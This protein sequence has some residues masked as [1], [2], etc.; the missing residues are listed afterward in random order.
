VLGPIEVLMLKVKQQAGRYALGILA[1]VIA[2]LLRGLLDPLLGRENPYHTVWLAVVFSTWY[3]GVG[4]AIVTTILS[5]AGVWFF[6]LPPIDSFRGLTYSQFFGM[7]GFL[8]LSG[9][10]IALG[11]SGRRALAK[12]LHAEE[13]LRRLHGEL[14]NGVRE[15]TAALEQKT[16]ELAE[17]ATMLDLANDAIFVRTAG[18]TVSYWN[19]GAERL[20]GWTK[21][22][23]LGHTMHDLL[24]T[25]FPVPLDD[26]KGRETWEGELRHTKR[27][28]TQITVASRWRTLRDPAGNALGWLEI[29]TDI[30]P[31]KRAEEAARRLSGRLLTLQDEEQRRIARELHDSLGQYLAALKMNIDCLP[32]AKLD[33]NKLI[34]DCSR[35]LETCLAETRTISH[36]LHPPLLDESGIVTAARWYVDEFARR[37]GIA[38]TFEVS[39]EGIRL[40]SEIEIA[41]FRA[42]QESLTNVHRHSGAKSVKIR[43]ARNGELVRLEIED[44][45]RGITSEQ[46]NR[47][48]EGTAEIGVGLAG[49]RERLRQ[50]DGSLEIQS[51]GA[52]TKVVVTTPFMEKE[53]SNTHILVA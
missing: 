36:L 31:R 15:R 20:Y 30:S 50:L 34:S 7:T 4:P 45:G 53:P 47:L 10:I 18:D 16:A 29:N 19:E 41:L 52:G 40:R 12:R 27:D 17:K 38:V 39:P 5:L 25:E 3:C 21:E 35:I 11:E 44:N 26:I 1:A 37:S 24:H 22:E 32:D 33:Q 6:F 14:E 42:I 13:E 49:M 23:V 2:L 43:L 9:V 28:G 48:A 46:L 8:V 51:T